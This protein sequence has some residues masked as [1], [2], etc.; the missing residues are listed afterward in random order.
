MFV[1]GSLAAVLFASKGALAVGS[2]FGFATGTTGGAAAAPA[3]PTST[4]Q[5][6]SWLSDST[7][8]TIVLD[9]TYDFTDTQG[10]TSET[11]CKPWTCSPN[12]QLAIN[13][14]NWCSSSAAKVSITYK[15]A[16]KSGLPVG[17]NKTILGK[18]T[19]GWIKGK[20]LKLAG[21][22][23][24]IIQNIRISDINHQYVWGGDAIDLQG[25]TN[26]WIDHNYFN[27]VGRQFI[28]THFD[29]NTKVTISNNYFDGRS[30]YSTG[31][32][33]HHY[34]AFLLLGKGDQITFARN[35]VYY[36]AGRGPHIGGT[37]GNTQ[38]LHMYNNYFND[39][40]G[41]ALDADVGATVLAE[42]NYFNNVKTPSTG[43]ANGAVF[44]PTSSTMAEQCSS[45]IGRK[46]VLN[47]FAGSGTLP[48]AAKNG[49]ISQFTASV[50]KSASVMD[51][52]SVP[53][54]VLANAGT[55]KVN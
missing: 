28:V 54:Y 35:H 7:T 29:P 55:G 41:H 36:T 12:P 37:S 20:G 45:S 4:T 26:V 13:A 19:S 24:V 33:N 34:W 47:T 18:G 31:C 8:R 6:A 38:L 40:T 42:G 25:A 39:I 44:A 50:V 53:S 21:S 46:C 14:N 17:S 49:I 2:P 5:L 27:R 23:N 10:S 51:Q 15:N 48:N 1:L 22:K 16:G 11:G 9:R 30:D 32:D 3:T 52:S 43:N